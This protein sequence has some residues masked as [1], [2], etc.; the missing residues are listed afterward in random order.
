MTNITTSTNYS[1]FYLRSAHKVHNYSDCNLIASFIIKDTRSC[2]DNIIDNCS[3]IFENNAINEYV[4][5]ATR[6]LHEYNFKLYETVVSHLLA[7]VRKT[8]Q[9]LRGKW[10]CRY[11]H[12]ILSLRHVILKTEVILKTDVNLK[13]DE[14]FSNIAKYTLRLEHFSLS[15]TVFMNTVV[16]PQNFNKEFLEIDLTFR[17]AVSITIPLWNMIKQF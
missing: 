16:V 15:L 3:A 5:G 8:C 11:L 10:P 14:M 7:F 2:R 13:T 1:H 4:A 17:Y 9:C 12:L 6:N